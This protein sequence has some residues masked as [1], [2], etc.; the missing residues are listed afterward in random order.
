MIKYII[1]RNFR[2]EDCYYSMNS[3]PSFP[4]IIGIFFLQFAGNDKKSN[5]SSVEFVHINDFKTNI[6][7]LTEFNAD[8]NSY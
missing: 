4:S 3:L 8:N 2:K 5:K 6:A 1:L 7:N